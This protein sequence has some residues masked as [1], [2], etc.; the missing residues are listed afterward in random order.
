MERVKKRKFGDSKVEVVRD[1]IVA[2]RALKEITDQHGFMRTLLYAVVMNK[3]KRRATNEGEDK[4]EEKARGWE[5]GSAMKATMLTTLTAA[6][7]VDEWANQFTEVQKVMNEQPWLS[8]MLEVIVKKL[9]L[10]SNLFLQA[11]RE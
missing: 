5:I 11:S 9:F 6:H 2:N 1:F 3:F 4:S 7:A 8:P 10:K